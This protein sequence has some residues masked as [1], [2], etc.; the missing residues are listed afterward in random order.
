MNMNLEELPQF[1]SKRQYLLQNRKDTEKAHGDLDRQQM[2]KTMIGILQN[3]IG[4]PWH[5]VDTL[6]HQKLRKFNKVNSSNIT[7]LIKTEVM[8]ETWL[9]NGQIMFHGF[10]GPERLKR[11][12]IW[13]NQPIYYV[14]PTTRTVCKQ[15]PNTP[16]KTASPVTK[17]NGQNPGEPYRLVNKVWYKVSFT[18][19]Q[20]DTSKSGKLIESRESEP[21]NGRQLLRQETITVEVQ[22]S[23]FH[24]GLPYPQDT[25]SSSS[26]IRI[27]NRG[28]SQVWARILNA[29][30]GCTYDELITKLESISWNLSDLPKVLSMWVFVPANGLGKR[31]WTPFL[32]DANGKLARNNKP[33]VFTS[34]IVI[35]PQIQPI[36]GKELHTVQTKSKESTLT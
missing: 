3:N 8:T 12:T 17:V 20:L 28:S 22:Q 11:R 14:D 30:I 2:H 35:K 6:L 13:F 7:S 10:C 1:L 25:I 26:Y 29:N 9:E 27:Q 16:K 32:I 36:G 24:K 21:R 23:S 33:H 4:Q 18:Q 5:T 31:S 34:Y 15:M 19:E